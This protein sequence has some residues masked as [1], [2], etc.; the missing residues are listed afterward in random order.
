MNINQLIAGCKPGFALPAAFY[1]ADE[2][3][4]RDVEQIVM[5][6]WI[7]ACHQSELAEVGSFRLLELAGES[8]VVVKTATGEIKAHFNVCRHRGSRV[9]LAESGR[10]Q[11]LVCPYH[12]WAYDLHGKL[13][14]SREMPA[15]F[16]KSAYGLKPASVSVVHGM[17]FVNFDA[18]A[19]PFL[20]F[21]TPLNKAL[22]IYDLANAQVAHQETWNVQANW[23]L[24]VENFMECYHCAPAH[25]EYAR[26]HS[27]KLPSRLSE[28][29]LGPMYERCESL[30]IYSETIDGE[31]GESG[32]WLNSIFYGR[33]PLFDGY[34]TGS[35]DGKPLAPLLGNMP[36]YDGAAADIQMGLMCYGLVYPDHAVIYSFLPMGKHST[37]MKIIWLVRGDAVEGVD[38]Q[39]DQLTWLWRVTTE[40]DKTI[41]LNN[42]LG[43][44]SRVY[45]PGPYAEMEAFTQLFV[46]WYLSVIGEE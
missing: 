14:N 36:D 29:L 37:D 22:D 12:G 18:D 3:Y 46:T 33:H 40:A 21:T 26:A 31:G 6:S 28:K 5:R 38:Y 41:I 34:V 27:L 23:K 8:V 44:N 10:A 39:R 35:E 7:Y 43:V 1:N 30:G 11:N 32:T 17:V 25:P 45:E 4:R 13:L 20:P 42:Q 9:C 24:A 2:I 16:D 19:A 15:G